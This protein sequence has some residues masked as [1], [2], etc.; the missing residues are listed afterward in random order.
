L[1]SEDAFFFWLIQVLFRT[2]DALFVGKFLIL[3]A[4]WDLHP[5]FASWPLICF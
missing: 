2:I 1:K 3:R 5:L 4:V